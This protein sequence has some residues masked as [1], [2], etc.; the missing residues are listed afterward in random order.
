MTTVTVRPDLANGLAVACELAG[1]PVTNRFGPTGGELNFIPDLTPEQQA[2][3]NTLAK[4]AVG[5]TLVTKA[6]RDSIESQLA[7][8]RIF[9][10]MS[11]SDFIALAQNARDRQ[12]FDNVTAIIRILRV[13]LRD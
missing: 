6:E 3:V 9:Q 5:A 7:T 2:T 8:I 4:L 11:Q 10:Q 13:F 1:I 12:L